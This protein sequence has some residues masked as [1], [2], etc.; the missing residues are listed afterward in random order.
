[1][2]DARPFWTPDGSKKAVRVHVRFVEKKNVLWFV[3]RHMIR[4]SERETFAVREFILESKKVVPSLDTLSTYFPYIVFCV[5]SV[6]GFLPSN[7]F[8]FMD[9]LTCLYITGENFLPQTTSNAKLLACLVGVKT[10]R[11]LHIRD[12]H[13]DFDTTPLADS[14]VEVLALT[15]CPK[16]RPINF[17]SSLV[18]TQ[19]F[20]GSLRALSLS[21][22]VALL[23]SGE[24]RDALLSLPNLGELR[25]NDDNTFFG[26]HAQRRNLVVSKS[27]RRVELGTRDFCGLRF[28]PHINDIVRVGF[29]LRVLTLR[30]VAFSTICPLDVVMNS[31]PM[32][33][34][35]DFSWSDGIRGEE[36]VP[37]CRRAKMLSLCVLYEVKP[38][39]AVDLL[40]MPRSS[41]ETA[42]GMP[43]LEVRPTMSDCVDSVQRDTM[44]PLPL[45]AYA[46]LYVNSESNKKMVS[47][48]RAG[49]GYCSYAT[50]DYC[51]RT[52]GEATARHNCDGLS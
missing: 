18:S 44:E 13:Q 35:L 1:M 29:G 16:L 38:M 19:K 8:K 5:I 17:L 51:Q 14:N 3:R 47:D 22:C 15:N 39:R 21:G 31:F 30:G 20:S 32:L 26:D 24:L 12:V 45:S 37:A 36:L 27:L 9:R 10:L 49:Y 34:S 50:N 7:A 41:T 48:L 42:D 2:S 28:T 23:Q 43:V 52:Q 11:Y 33:E 4:I 40:L 25:A 6:P 46:S